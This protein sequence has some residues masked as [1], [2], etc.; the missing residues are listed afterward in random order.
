M[1]SSLSIRNFVI[2]DT[3]DLNFDGGFTVLTGETGAG[4]SI[5]IDALSLVLGARGDADVIRVGCDKTEIV[6]HFDIQH[7]GAAQDFLRALELECEQEIVLRRVLYRDG[8]SRAFINGISS[9]VTELKILGEL[10]VDI[11]SQNAHHSLLKTSTQRALLDDFGDHAALVKALS[12]AF[13]VWQTFHQQR[14]DNEKQSSQRHQELASL[15]DE[16]RELEA[17]ALSEADWLAMNAQQKSLSHGADIISIGTQC[18]AILSKNE[19]SVLALALRASRQIKGLVEYDAGLNEIA[20]LLASATIQLQEGTRHLERYLQNLHLDEAQ[21]AKIDHTLQAIHLVSRRYQVHPENMLN[22]LFAVKARLQ[23][24]QNLSDYQ[25]LAAQEEAA[26]AQYHLLAEQLSSARRAAAFALMQQMDAKLKQL[27]LA[28]G[29]FEVNLTASEPSAYGK[30]NVEFLV[31]THTASPARALNKVVSGGELSRLSLGLR[32]VSA[33]FSQTPTMIF[34]EVDVGIGGRVAE[35]VGQLLKALGEQSRQVL[36][37]T[38]LPQV[39]ALADQHLRVQ[40]NNDAQRTS[41]SINLLS[42]EER[43]EE[44]AR[45]LGGIDITETTRQHARE[46]LGMAV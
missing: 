20:E 10:L 31:A 26:H 2:V 38:H 37:I 44:I 22:H 23:E 27:A 29:R 14:L 28:D 33:Q 40:K 36:V 4:K 32:V 11:Y 21:L 25:V 3:L 9:T 18:H 17:V 39:A 45:M 34:D 16:I 5:L 43:V 35:V 1:L 15:R 19:T 8:R 46:M 12:H 6:A 42:S 30:E 41:S 24:L 7:I 13:K